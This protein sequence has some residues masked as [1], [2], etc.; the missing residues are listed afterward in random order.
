MAGFIIALFSI[1]YDQERQKLQ[2]GPF[3]K[4]ITVWGCSVF[5]IALG[6]YIATAAPTVSFWDCGEFIAASYK[7]QVPHPPGAPL[8]LLIGRLFSMFAMDKE[9]V[10]FSINMVSVVSS[11]FTILLVHA[12]IVLLVKKVLK[13]PAP[14]NY[15]QVFTILCCSTTGSLAFAF[16]DSFWFNAVEAEVYALSCF[17]TALTFWAILK[18]DADAG[19]PGAE[20]WIVFIAYV[21]GLSIGVHLLNLVTIPALAVVVYFK[22]YTPTLTGI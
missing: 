7:L 2:R 6:V 3:D 13:I 4:M 17:F 20:R 16:S 22:M 8:F 19:H 10:A 15:A 14:E 12:S 11:A 1:F 21:T 5:F 9:R 18:W